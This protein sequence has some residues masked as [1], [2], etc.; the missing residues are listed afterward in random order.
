MDII[1]ALLLLVSVGVF[2][3]HILDALRTGSGS[4][5]RQNES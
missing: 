5:P 1:V 2:A 3:A 4:H